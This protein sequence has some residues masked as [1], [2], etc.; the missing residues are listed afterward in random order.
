MTKT[1]CPECNKPLTMSYW[2][3]SHNRGKYKVIYSNMSNI[4]TKDWSYTSVHLQHTMKQV[5]DLDG[6]VVMDETR[7]GIML[8][9]K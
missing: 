5:L 4:G 6:F 3:C 9:L 2:G 1:H 7:I 8:L